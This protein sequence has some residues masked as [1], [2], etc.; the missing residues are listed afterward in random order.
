MKWLTNHLAPTS[1][2]QE[3]HVARDEES[4]I[5]YTFISHFRTPC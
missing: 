2:N 1:A 4:D 5:V 3:T